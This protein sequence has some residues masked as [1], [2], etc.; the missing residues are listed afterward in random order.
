MNAT[1]IVTRLVGFGW[2]LTD[3]AATEIIK[4]RQ[5]LA[6]LKEQVAAH[7]ERGSNEYSEGIL[8]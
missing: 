2:P 7:N 4:L 6:K 3:D 1:D 8:G 5:E